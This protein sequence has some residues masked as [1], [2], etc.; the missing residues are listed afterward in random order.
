MEFIHR[1]QDSG[2]YDNE[3]LEVFTR[4][5]HIKNQLIENIDLLLDRGERLD[6]ALIKSKNMVTE[7]K[8]IK[9]RAKKYNNFHKRRKICYIF[10][11]TAI[12]VAI[13]AIMA[14]IIYFLL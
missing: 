14:V 13:I 5:D 2:D 6:V 7:S 9:K 10:W 1:F 11:I 8:T 3:P 4:F 12:L